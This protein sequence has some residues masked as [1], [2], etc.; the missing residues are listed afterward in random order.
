MLAGFDSEVGCAGG[1]VGTV[2]AG[3]AFHEA[4]GGFGVEAFDVAALA[5][6]EGA[7]DADDEEA[8]LGDDGGDEV[9]K[10]AGGGDEGDDDGEAGLHGE[11]GHVSGAADVFGAVLKGEAEV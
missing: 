5:F 2:H 11:F 6:G 4:G 9:A 7:V 3:H 1:F 8:V 10:V